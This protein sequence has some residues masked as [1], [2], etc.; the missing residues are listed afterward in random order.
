MIELKGVSAGIGTIGILHGIDLSVPSSGIVA[1]LGANGAGK[2][3]LLRV[4]SRVW[5]VLEGEIRFNG[6]VIN[7]WKSHDVAR[8][9]LVQVPQGRQIIPTLT[10]EDN[11]LIGALHVP[12][13]TAVERKAGLEREYV[14]FP[15]L[16]ERRR[17]PGGSLSGGEQQMLAISRALMMQPKL[18]MLDEPSLGLAPMLVDGIMASL[19]DLA[20]AGTAVLLV[21]QAA[22][23]ALKVASYGYVLQQGKVAL[24]GPSAEL[25]ATSDLI[26]SYLG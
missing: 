24:K 17:T 12:A 6:Q 14:R 10:V 13:L 16:A 3:T 11:L 19:V 7:G 9:G 1:I 20:R 18:I 15:I 2:T 8:A 21:E 5:P 22:M 26:R 25:L 23:A 4:I